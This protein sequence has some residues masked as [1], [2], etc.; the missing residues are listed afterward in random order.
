MVVSTLE[1]TIVKKNDFNSPNIE[2]TLTMEKY[3]TWTKGLFD[4]NYQIFEQGQIKNSLLFNSYKNEARSVGA[5]QNLLFVTQGFTNQT[6]IIYDG[7]NLVLGKIT[8]NSWQARATVTLNSGVQ[9]AWRFTNGWLSNWEITNFTD[10]KINYN[11]SSSSG[12]IIS[13]TDDELMLIAGL[14]IKEYYARIL[15]LILLIVIISTATSNIF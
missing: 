7:K 15:I 6:T 10:K 12:T 13:N 8:Y 4:S 11:S 9:L 3:L 14:F 5:Q 1:F 2:N